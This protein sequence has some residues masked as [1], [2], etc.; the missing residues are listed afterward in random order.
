[1]SLAWGVESLIIPEYKNTRDLFNA[2]VSAA[3]RAGVV[4]TDERVILTAGVPIGIK[5]STNLLKVQ[6]AG[7][8]H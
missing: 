5:G 3:M 8:Y 7:E 1:M 6:I 2:A 4:K